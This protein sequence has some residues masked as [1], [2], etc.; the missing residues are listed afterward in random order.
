VDHSPFVVEDD[1]GAGAGVAGWGWLGGV[2]AGGGVL[3]AALE[4]ADPPL[5]C[6]LVAT[7]GEDCVAGSLR[8]CSMSRS[9]ECTV[10]PEMTSTTEM[11][12]T[13]CDGLDFM[14]AS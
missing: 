12:C 1:A 4:P 8:G 9:C 10:H 6:E 11:N 3:A 5:V 2:A 13:I 7:G 14:L